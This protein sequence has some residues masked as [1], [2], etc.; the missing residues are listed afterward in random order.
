VKGCG[1]LEQKQLNGRPRELKP[2]EQLLLFFLWLR[3]FMC[4]YFLGW[5]FGLHQSR[6]SN[7]IN[8]TLEIAYEM[9][10]RYIQW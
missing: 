7:Y 4:E 9:L 5:L 6:I 2:K 1:E 3:H 10:K 8:T